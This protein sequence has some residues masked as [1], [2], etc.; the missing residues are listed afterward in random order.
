MVCILPTDRQEL[1][2][3]RQSKV[4]NLEKGYYQVIAFE[5]SMAE[6]ML[7]KRKIVDMKMIR[8]D[9]GSNVTITFS[10]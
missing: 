5:G 6:I 3:G 4:V 8:I 9:P 2:V 7:G 1:L 10:K